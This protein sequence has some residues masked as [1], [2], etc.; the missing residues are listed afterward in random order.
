[1]RE[2]NLVTAT[3]DMQL[4]IRACF[5]NDTADKTLTASYKLGSTLPAGRRRTDKVGDN[6]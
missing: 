4:K 2:E 5:A 1:M 3:S 6:W